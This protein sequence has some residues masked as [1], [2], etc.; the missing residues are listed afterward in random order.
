MRRICEGAALT[1]GVEI[2]FTFDLIFAPLTNDPAAVD[3]VV[4]TAT[5]IVGERN[6]DRNKLPSMASED[7]SFML[8]NTPGA[9]VHIGNGVTAP[10]HNSQYDFN[11]QAIPYGAT[12]FARLVEHELAV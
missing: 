10:V 11:D 5:E 9:Y 3:R 4:A 7:F 6:V 1:F 12:L 8:E 2:D